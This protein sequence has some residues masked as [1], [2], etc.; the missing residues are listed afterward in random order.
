MADPR[1]SIKE[2]WIHAPSRRNLIT[3][4]LESSKAAE[5]GHHLDR[6]SFGRIKECG[7]KR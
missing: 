7:K 1:E 5:A 3:S 2:F 6:E 4:P